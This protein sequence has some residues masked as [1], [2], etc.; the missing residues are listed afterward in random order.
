MQ[1]CY[2]HFGFELAVTIKQLTKYVNINAF[3]IPNNMLYFFMHSKNEQEQNLDHYL[4]IIRVLFFYC[5]QAQ[6]YMQLCTHKLTLPLLR[7]RLPLPTSS[8]PDEN[9]L[10]WMIKKIL[11]A[12]IGRID[13]HHCLSLNFI[14]CSCLSMINLQ[15]PAHDYLFLIL[16]DYLNTCE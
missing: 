3:C 8:K 11:I 12:D 6:F 7:Q 1:K 16:K 9:L 13:D 4:Q 15:L 10:P 5:F 14:T 2:Y